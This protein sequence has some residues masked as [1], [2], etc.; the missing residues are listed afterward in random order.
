MRVLPSA[1][2]PYFKEKGI[3]FGAEYLFRF[4]NQPFGYNSRRKG[5]DFFITSKSISENYR[6][7][8][9]K[10]KDYTYFVDIFGIVED[11]SVYLY[12][13]IEP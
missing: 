10:V 7:Q 5:K 11:K 6:D 13:M 12:P 9:N 8:S 2:G 4:L 1:L 3:Q